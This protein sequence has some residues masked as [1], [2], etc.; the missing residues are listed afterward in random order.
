MSWT[1]SLNVTVIRSVDERQF[2]TLIVWT[3]LVSPRGAFANEIVPSGGA[4]AGM[5]TSMPVWNGC[6]GKEREEGERRVAR[7]AGLIP[8]E[9]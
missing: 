2:G 1:K 8:L 5:N 6:V 7:R 3:R 9:T 4:A